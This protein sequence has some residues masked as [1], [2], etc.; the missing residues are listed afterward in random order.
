M[1]PMCIIRHI[2]DDLEK[3]GQGQIDHQNFHLA[4]SPAS[5]NSV[6]CYLWHMDCSTVL[7][8]NGYL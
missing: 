4:M 7:C 6:V 5:V 2:C 1:L 8:Y 3:I